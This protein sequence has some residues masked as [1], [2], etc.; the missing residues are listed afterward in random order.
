MLGICKLTAFVFFSLLQAAA[1][2]ELY[3]VVGSN[4]ME[5]QLHSPYLRAYHHNPAGNFTHEHTF[6][7][8]AIT[9]DL[10]IEK[11]VLERHIP[12]TDACS[13][14]PEGPIAAAFMELFPSYGV[15]TVMDLQR[16]LVIMHPESKFGIMREIAA[17][18]PLP[19]EENP[20]IKRELIKIRNL[21]VG[22]MLTQ[23]SKPYEI[24]DQLMPHAIAN[25]AKYMK[26]GAN[27]YIE[28]IPLC[29][30]KPTANPFS[31][32]MRLQFLA[33]LNVALTDPS[34]TSLCRQ[35]VDL[36]QAAVEISTG[37][38]R[39]T[40]EEYCAKLTEEVELCRTPEAF[41]QS[42]SLLVLLELERLEQSLPDSPINVFLISQ[43]FTNITHE[44]VTNPF[45]GRSNSWMITAV[46]A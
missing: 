5:G 40:R 28:H 16:M 18:V 14:V 15:Q 41:H 36:V 42:L 31:L 2:A 6:D 13:F 10:R 27:L 46:K 17:S 7:G 19:L 21:I 9:V 44:R 38:I 4:K 35:A 20:E 45:N 43:G 23:I 8:R 30:N 3:L 29:A 25:L 11:G 12:E 39:L 33:E 37:E 24:D 1:P 22:N 26:T 34:S 32:G